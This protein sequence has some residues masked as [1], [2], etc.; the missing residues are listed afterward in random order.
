MISRSEFNP[1][2][3]VSTRCYVMCGECSVTSVN[4]WHLDTNCFY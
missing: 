4:R 3:L 1:R 2:E